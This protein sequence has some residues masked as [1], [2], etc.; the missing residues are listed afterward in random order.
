MNM[1]EGNISVVFLA[2]FHLHKSIAS[3]TSKLLSDAVK[4]S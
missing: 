2:F 3:I 1:M 4:L